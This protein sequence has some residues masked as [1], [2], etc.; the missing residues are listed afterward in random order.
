MFRKWH[1]T[2]AFLSVKFATI[3]STLHKYV[4]GMKYKGG[5]P[6]GM[7]YKSSEDWLRKQQ[8]DPDVNRGVSGSGLSAAELPR[9]KGAG[10]ETGKK[11]DVAEIWEDSSKP[12]KRKRDTQDDEDD[13][14]DDGGKPHRA[15][16]MRKG[17]IIAN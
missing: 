2:T 6:P 7:S 10:K 12:S 15:P 14:D 16:V 11:R 9:V 1:I 4:V 3:S 13:D 17:I 5:A 8:E